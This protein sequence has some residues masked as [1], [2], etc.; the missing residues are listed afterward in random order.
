[1]LF[2]NFKAGAC[3]PRE[4]QDTDIRHK[5]NITNH[6]EVSSLFPIFATINLNNNW[7]FQFRERA[8]GATAGGSAYPRSQPSTAA[9]EW[10][11]ASV[12]GQGMESMPY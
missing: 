1:M 2:F 6:L 12:Q 8:D 7:T 3:E 5:K 10:S 4:R 9:K 11:G